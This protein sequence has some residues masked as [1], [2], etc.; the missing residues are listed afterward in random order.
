MFEANGVLWESKKMKIVLCKRDFP[1][2][3]DLPWRVLGLYK[4]EFE[5]AP[6]YNAVA[7]KV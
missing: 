1:T 3:S 4:F 5:F 7:E 6:L 2:Q